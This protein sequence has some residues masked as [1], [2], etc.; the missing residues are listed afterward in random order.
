MKYIIKNKVYFL[1]LTALLSLSNCSKFL[2]VE[3]TMILESENAI[4]TVRDLEAVLFGAYDGLQSG[5]LLGGNL[6]VNAELL[7]TD[8][9]INESRLSPFGTLEIYNMV[10]TV[11]IGALRSLWS[12][13]YSTI[14]RANIVIDF[15]DNNKLSGPE[16]DALKVKLKGEALFIRAVAHYEILRFWAHAYDVNNTGGNSQLG[17]PYRTIATYEG[18][19]GLEMA[20]TNVEDVY[21]NVID[22]LKLSAQLLA[23]SGTTTSVYRASEMSARAY[24]AKVLFFKGDY[25]NAAIEADYVIESQVFSL[26]DSVQDIYQTSGLTA[27]NESIFQI[28]NIESDNSNAL[29]GNFQRIYNP[30]IQVDTNFYN[31]FEDNDLR[32]IKLYFKNPWTGAVFVTKY[33]QTNTTP[34]NISVLRLAEQHLIRAEALALSGGDLSTAIESYNTVR[35]RAHLTAIPTDT[36]FSDINVFVNMLREEH[37]KEL[38]F[39]GDNL[40]NLKRLKQNVRHGKAYNDNSILFKIPQE[41]MSG[42]SLMEQNP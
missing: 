12:E 5:N 1:V 15:V 23:Q 30:L 24:L 17:V 7:G 8:A 16:F 31:T 6:I 37:R 25:A 36:T 14:N 38:A 34:N 21:Q 10:T 19:E 3:P 4:V 27:S 2:D 11:Q 33:D 9:T 20:R 22:D 28:A 18:P 26:N 41:E 42:N 39:E 29:S 13:A 40:H 32:K 35:E